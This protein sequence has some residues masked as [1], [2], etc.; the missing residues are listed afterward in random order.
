MRDRRQYYF[1]GQYHYVSGPSGPIFKGLGRKEVCPGG[2]K[3]EVKNSLDDANRIR[4]WSDH[5]AVSE[6]EE[7]LIYEQHG[8]GRDGSGDEN[9]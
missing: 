1:A 3:C 2:R 9:S 6:E 7:R 8:K 4:R 5:Q